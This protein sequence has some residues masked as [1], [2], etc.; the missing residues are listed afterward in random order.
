MCVRYRYSAVPRYMGTC[1]A[2]PR[3][4]GT[5]LQV[6]SEFCRLKYMLLMIALFDVR[7]L[8]KNRD[9]VGFSIAG[10]HHVADRKMDEGLKCRSLQGPKALSCRNL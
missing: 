8:H 1:M 6:L 10:L 4:R 9:P 2:A 7:E 5:D 3:Y